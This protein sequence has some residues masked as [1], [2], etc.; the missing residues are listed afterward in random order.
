VEDAKVLSIIE[1][2]LKRQF[3]FDKRFQSVILAR[4]TRIREDLRL[5]FLD[6]YTL[7]CWLELEDK[8]SI[9]EEIDNFSTIGEYI[10]YI[11]PQLEKREQEKRTREIDN[12][13][14]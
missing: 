4:K 1:K 9:I 14:I 3:L 11:K 2:K 12:Y 13:Q 6:C 8:I 7:G 5:D 10:D